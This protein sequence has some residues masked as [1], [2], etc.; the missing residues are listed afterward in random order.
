MDEAPCQ[1]I[2]R[3][4]VPMREID[5]EMVNRVLSE[6]YEITDIVPYLDVGGGGMQGYRRGLFTSNLLFQLN[7]SHRKTQ[8]SFHYVQRDNSLKFVDEINE[9]IKHEN[10]KERSLIKIIPGT[11]IREPMDGGDLGEGTRAFFLFFI[12]V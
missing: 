12:D 8:V 10:E 6:G 5:L 7:P 4:H 1:K 11:I 2:L 9:I 3:S